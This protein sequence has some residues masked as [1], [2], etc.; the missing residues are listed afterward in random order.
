M[1]DIVFLVAGMSSRFNGNPKQMAKIGPNNETLIEISVNQASTQ[2]FN[3]IYF[4]TNINTQSLFVNIFGN[5]YR[6]KCVYYIQQNYDLKKRVR[7]WGTTD[8]ICNLLDTN[9]SEKFILVNGDD[10]YGE[11]T[12]KLGY[13]NLLKYDNII[14]GIKVIKTITNDNLCNRGIITQ[15]DGIVT[16]LI[17]M[18]NIS[19]NKN[20]ELMQK[21]ANVN[22][23]GL[24]KSTLHYLSCN[25]FEF[26]LKH[27]DDPKIECLLPNNLNELILKKLIIMNYFEIPKNIIGITYPEDVEIIKSIFKNFHLN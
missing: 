10:I 24:S 3:S 2:N 20:P 13:E 21:L 8:A 11:E 19:K 7:P 6:N 9:I 14:G 17:E 5:K 27:E 16:N 18:L 25:L 15:E 23:I 12:F 26:K 1:I 4:I 22:F